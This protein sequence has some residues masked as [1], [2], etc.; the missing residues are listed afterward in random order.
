M[1]SF[2]VGKWYK[3]GSR[4]SRAYVGKYAG[5]APPDGPFA[6]ASEDHHKFTDV[7]EVN[8][9]NTL[10][11]MHGDEATRYVHPAY[12]GEGGTTVTKLDVE[13]E[14]T[15]AGGRRRRSHRRRSSKQRKSLRRKTRRR[16]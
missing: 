6:N 11:P 16:H 12:L 7:R 13:G 3:V 15:H 1:A 2:E 4:L 8:A 9:D 14:P 10:T 5:L